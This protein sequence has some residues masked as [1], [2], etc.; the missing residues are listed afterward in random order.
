MES[1]TGRRRLFHL[2]N[3]LTLFIFHKIISCD[4][5]KVNGLSLIAQLVKNPHAMQDTRVRVRG[6]EDLLEK[7]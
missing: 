5:L 4:F 6:Q 2:S 7:G 3:L 1:R